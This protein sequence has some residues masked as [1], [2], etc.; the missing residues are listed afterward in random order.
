MRLGI[1]GLGHSMLSV[2][3]RLYGAANRMGLFN[4]PG[5]KQAYQWAYF[6][7]KKHLEDPFYSLSRR[8]PALFGHGEILDV[9]ANIGYTAWVFAGA[10]RARGGAGKV[11]AFEPELENFTA[12]S[13]M[14]RSSGGRIV[15][16]R[17]A[18]GQARP[19]EKAEIELWLNEKHRADHRVLTGQLSDGLRQSGVDVSKVQTVPLVALDDYARARGWL[20][21]EDR[22]GFVKIDVQGFEMSVLQSMSELLERNPRIAVAFE[23]DPAMFRQMGQDPREVPAFLAARG[24]AFRRIHQNGQLSSVTFDENGNACGPGAADKNYLDVLATREIA[25]GN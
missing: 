3:P 13:Q 8:H 6:S 11:H 4:L 16:V 17:A 1:M 9:G 10:L 2:L 20:D 24:F 15:P 25:R 19:G 23:Y 14:A 18:V 7:Y 22:I 21:G 5:T 12:L